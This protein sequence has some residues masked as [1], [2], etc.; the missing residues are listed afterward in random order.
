M[1]WQ[2]CTQNKPAAKSS[3]QIVVNQDD[4]VLRIVAGILASEVRERQLAY[5]EDLNPGLWQSPQNTRQRR[6]ADA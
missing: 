4:V 3:E 6:L 5:S 1:T 2:T